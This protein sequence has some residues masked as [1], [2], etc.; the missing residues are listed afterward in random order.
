MQVVAD[1]YEI[2]TMVKSGI[3]SYQW[4]NKEDKL[5]YIREQVQN[6]IRHP[7]MCLRRGSYL[8]PEMNTYSSFHL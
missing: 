3:S 8:I 4:P 5:A 1:G 6:K 7:N 2:A